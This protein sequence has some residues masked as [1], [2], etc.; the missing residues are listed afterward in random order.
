MCR[1]R[2]GQE[3]AN[4]ARGGEIARLWRREWWWWWGTA[5]AVTSLAARGA[6]LYGREIDAEEMRRPSRAVRLSSAPARFSAGAGSA[7]ARLRAGVGSAVAR[8]RAGGRPAS[9]P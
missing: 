5:V 1:V 9:A 2:L 6:R 4:Q 8:L 7:V 3:I